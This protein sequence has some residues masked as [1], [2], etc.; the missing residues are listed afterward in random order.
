MIFVDVDETQT[1]LSKLIDR[2]TAGEEVIVVDGGRRVARIIAYEAREP[3]KP[4]LLAGQI[5]IAPDFEKLP[6]GFPE[7]FGG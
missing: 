3:R 2:V 4:G 5:E 6:T 7:A 1:N